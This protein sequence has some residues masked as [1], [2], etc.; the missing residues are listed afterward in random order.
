[1][2]L[3]LSKVH[4]TNLLNKFINIH[5]LWIEGSIDEINKSS[6]IKILK[7]ES[8]K[9]NQIYVK[10]EEK[11][12]PL[13]M[14]GRIYRSII[15]LEDNYDILTSLFTMKKTLSFLQAIENEDTDH[16]HIIEYSNEFNLKPEQV[17]KILKEYEHI[18]FNLDVNTRLSDHLIFERD[19]IIDRA[20]MI[21]QLMKYKNISNYLLLNR[22]PSKENPLIPRKIEVDWEE[23]RSFPPECFQNKSMAHHPVLLENPTKVIHLEENDYRLILYKLSPKCTQR[24]LFAWRNDKFLISRKIEASI[25]R[26]SWNRMISEYI[27]RGGS[28]LFISNS[29]VASFG[30]GR[31]ITRYKIFDDAEFFMVPPGPILRKNGFPATNLNKNDFC[32]YFKKTLRDKKYVFVRRL[33]TEVNGYEGNKPAVQSY[34]NLDFMLCSFAP[35][36]SWSY[37]LPEAYDEAVKDYLLHSFN[38]FYTKPPPTP[39]YTH[40]S[41]NFPLLFKG[42]TDK[43]D[44]TRNVLKRN[45]RYLLKKSGGIYYNPVLKKTEKNIKNH[46]R[47]IPSPPWNM[48]D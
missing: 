25:M 20:A 41:P 29:P 13:K 47:M 45:L 33:E 17:I 35:V 4:A 46:L 9:D 27:R 30:Y 48:L 10:L 42:I 36:H 28:I 6:P 7:D 26:R 12:M 15:K 21:I 8:T 24:V 40:L 31:N 18:L 22:S 43:K 34:I 3:N 11:I 2:L 23:K 14:D 44:F 16:P 39:L 32:K 19:F 37:N 1:M 38:F 5:E